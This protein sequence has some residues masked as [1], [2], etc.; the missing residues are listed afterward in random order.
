ME[1][2]TKIK[3]NR[4][5]ETH[6]EV[7]GSGVYNITTEVVHDDAV[8]AAKNPVA[9]VLHSSDLPYKIPMGSWSWNERRVPLVVLLFG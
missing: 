9:G 7:I 6:A 4:T 8:L 2:K 1:G 3:Q 5:F